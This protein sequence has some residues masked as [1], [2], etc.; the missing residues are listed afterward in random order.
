MAI[1][2]GLS[3]AVG[4]WPEKCVQNN[5]N[6][7]AVQPRGKA[8]SYDVSTKLFDKYKIDVKIAKFRKYPPALRINVQIR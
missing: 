4:V 2:F 7:Y 5:K 1:L 8:P 3:A 6:V